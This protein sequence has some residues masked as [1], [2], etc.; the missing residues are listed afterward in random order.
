MSTPSGRATRAVPILVVL[1]AAMVFAGCG[2]GAPSAIPSAAPV[3]L[4]G[5]AWKAI[6]VAG[7]PTVAGTEP[8]AAFNADGV[9]GT[10]GCNSYGGSYRYAPGSIH[11][12]NLM[13]TAMGCFGVI[14]TVEQRFV[15][16]LNG[17]SSASLDPTG[18]L[19]VDGAGGSIT[20][21]AGAQSDS[22]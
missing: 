16:A 6:L 12:G 8:T 20:F 19:I 10:T 22:S 4:A 15:A 7:Q 2:A 18:R 13:S 17:A 14:S 9:E 11:F 5:T 21:V 1:L 3:S